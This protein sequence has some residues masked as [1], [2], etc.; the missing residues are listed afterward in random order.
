MRTLAI[1][2]A[3]VVLSACFRRE[4][5]FVPRRSE[6]ITT[7][8]VTRSFEPDSTH[9]SCDSKYGADWK[10]LLP[11]IK[12]TRNGGM[13]QKFTCYIDIPKKRGPT[14]QGRAFFFSFLIYKGLDS[15]A[16]FCYNI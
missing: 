5:D 1:A 16:F 3:V 14:P 4:P 10:L 2:V 12:Y 15:M 9:R 11:E 13:K 8:R 6:E 7:R